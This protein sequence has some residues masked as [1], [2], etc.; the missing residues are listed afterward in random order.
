[1]TTDHSTL[2]SKGQG[3]AFPGMTFRVWATVSEIYD[4]ESDEIFRCAALDVRHA[5]DKLDQRIHAD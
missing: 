2:Q 5:G 4:I 1:M 3:C